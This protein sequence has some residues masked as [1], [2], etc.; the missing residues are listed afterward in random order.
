MDL[1][2]G[3]N[4]DHIKS[5]HSNGFFHLA[6]FTAHTVNGFD[7]AK[8]FAIG[9]VIFG[10]SKVTLTLKWSKTLQDSDHIRSVILS[11]LKIP[12]ICHFK[13]FKN[14]SAV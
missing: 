14:I 12:L 3:C 6:N 13:A 10:K 5:R 1:K 9:Y 2:V 8:Q 4:L 7:P 11:M